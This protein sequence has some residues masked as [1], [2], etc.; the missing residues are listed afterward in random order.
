MKEFCQEVVTIPVGFDEI[1][2][3]FT[4][5]EEQFENILNSMNGFQ[6]V[7]EEWSEWF[8]LATKELNECQTFQANAIEEMSENLDRIQVC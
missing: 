1:E 6:E 2:Q 5:I 3:E 8:Q 4:K 7:Y